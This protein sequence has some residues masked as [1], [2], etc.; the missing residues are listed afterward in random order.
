MKSFFNEEL[1]IG[2]RVL[3]FPIIRTGSS[4]KR[5]VKAVGK[6]TK[7]TKNDNCYIK[8]EYDDYYRTI[9]GK[10]R[11]CREVIAK[12]PSDWKGDAE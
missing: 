9:V 1:N 8:V 3:F 11:L 2:D 4:T 10:E 6:I 12:V 7:F 5:A